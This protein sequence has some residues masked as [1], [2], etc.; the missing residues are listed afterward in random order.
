MDDAFA[1]SYDSNLAPGTTLDRIEDSFG[2]DR[3]Q[4]AEDAEAARLMYDDRPT[5]QPEAPEAPI[6]GRHWYSACS[7]DYAKVDRHGVCEGCGGLACPGCGREN[8][9]DDCATVIA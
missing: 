8:C 9:P 1:Y 4:E 2:S 3:W 6:P 7:D 5:H